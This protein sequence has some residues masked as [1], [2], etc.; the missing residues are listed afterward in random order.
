MAFE[1]NQCGDC[2][3]HLG[4]V[5]RIIQDL[6]DHRYVVRNEYTGE[7][8]TVTVAPGMLSLFNDRRTL[9]DRPEACPFFRFARENGKGYCCVHA[10]RPEICRDYGCW[11]ILILDRDGRR[12]GRIMASRH[13]AS[14]DS[15]LL[16]LFREEMALHAELSDSEWDRVIIRMVHAAGY[17]VCR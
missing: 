4:L 7:R 5:H 9:V 3:S 16:R 8:T 11:R 2:C 15:D 14:E 12:V 13:L 10:T 1:C 17:R 6:G